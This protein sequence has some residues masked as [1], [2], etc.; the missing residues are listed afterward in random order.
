MK[1][2][3][4]LFLV[5]LPLI[6]FAARN[7]EL[8]DIGGGGKEP[9]TVDGDRF[10]SKLLEDGQR[11]TYL[12]GN[13]RLV[14]GDLTIR[15]DKTTLYKERN[16]A[17]LDGNV[18]ITQKGMRATAK[19]GVYQRAINRLYLEGNAHIVD[20]DNDLKAEKVTY[21]RIKKQAV[22]EKNVIIVNKKHQTTITGEYALW[23][24]NEESGF[25]T[26]N[27]KM[28]IIH[29]K[30][31]YTLYAQK[32][33]IYNKENKAVA[34]QDVRM[35]SKDINALCGVGTFYRNQGRIV[36]LGEPVLFKDNRKIYGDEIVMYIEDQEVNEVIV[37]GNAKAEDKVKTSLG[38]KINWVSGDKII[39]NLGDDG[40][41]QVNVIGNAKSVY[42]YED[43]EEKSGV[44]KN[45]MTG[46]V[47]TLYWEKNTRTSSVKKRKSD[48]SD[49]RL[50]K[51]VV[52]GQVQGTYW[53]PSRRKEM[54]I[55]E[56]AE[57]AKIDEKTRE[58]TV[59]KTDKSD[60]E[61][62]KESPE[63]IKENEK[64]DR[65]NSGK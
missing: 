33:E 4:S 44:G 51:I 31:T 32:L 49:T 2:N 56:T 39:I 47:I 62:K 55:D 52:N 8:S 35:I 18:V 5:F 46:D 25:I 41:E 38:T 22:C 12:T 37:I 9:Y 29:E 53:T 60:I 3:F 15:C 6:V 26:E 57:K 65:G 16:L 30:V 23:D 50:T 17:Y 58:G 24:R 43:E 61:E 63:K 7:D 64:D 11:V 19:K 1:K 10:E 48:E 36:M 54:T 34:V 13:C 21:Y 28:V 14:H 20:G 40:I 45:E 42:F 27:P 59:E